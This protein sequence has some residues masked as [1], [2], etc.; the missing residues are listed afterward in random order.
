MG[1]LGR[2]STLSARH[3]CPAAQSLGSTGNVEMKPNW[4]EKHK[5]NNPLLLSPLPPPP[6]QFPSSSSYVHVVKNS[7][8][9]ISIP[10]TPPL[11]LDQ[12]FLLSASRGDLCRF[13]D[14]RRG[15]SI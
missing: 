11:L 7:H 2:G 10:P 8:G 9:T 14:P 12:Q 13:R 3:P 4:E 6:S 5:N 15:L 1:E